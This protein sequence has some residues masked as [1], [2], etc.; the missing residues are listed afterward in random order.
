MMG[1]FMQLFG[2]II[3]YKTYNYILN[4]S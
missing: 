4:I 1:F 2:I 3:N